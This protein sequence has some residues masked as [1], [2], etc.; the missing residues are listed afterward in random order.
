[1]YKLIIEL[2]RQE[3]NGLNDGLFH[4]FNLL[5]RVILKAEIKFLIIIGDIS[6]TIIEKE[7]PKQIQIQFDNNLLGEI[8]F[9][10]LT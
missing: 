8:L 7:N 3:Y 4:L 9:P 6:N 5:G 1:M 10:N 2:F